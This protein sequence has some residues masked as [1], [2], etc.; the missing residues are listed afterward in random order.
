[1]AR[2]KYR[3]LSPDGFDINLE[4]GFSSM[5]KAIA[6]FKEWVG[7]YKQQGYYS[8]ARYGRIDLRDL[9]D[10]CTFVKL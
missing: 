9:E 2:M 3:I 5:K 10:C 1:M 7:R 4:G 8:S 6:Y